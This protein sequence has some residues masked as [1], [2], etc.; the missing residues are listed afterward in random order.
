MKIEFTRDEYK[1]LL[2]MM[3]IAEWILN[4]YKV[5]ADPR[6]E[7][8]KELEQK[9]YSYAKDMGFED[10]IEYA[11]EYEMHFPTRKFE[12]TGLAMKFIDEFE[13]DTFWDEL[14]NRLADRDFFRQIGGSENLSK[15][16]LEKRSEMI[17]DLEEK[18]HSAF[19][20]RGLDAIS[21]VENKE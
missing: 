3:Y 1:H 2:D 7:V 6:T 20:E 14:T 19:V 18:Y 21:L 8:Y 10:L 11:P 5:G 13:N 17:G 9:I 16:S 4:A 15:F 12:E